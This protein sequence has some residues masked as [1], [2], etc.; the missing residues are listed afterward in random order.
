[1]NF[2]NNLRMDT[3]I[4]FKIYINDHKVSKLFIKLL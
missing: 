3:K 1:M 2:K 4:I